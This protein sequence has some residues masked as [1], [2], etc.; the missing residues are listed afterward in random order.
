[1]R[2]FIGEIIDGVTILSKLPGTRWAIECPVCGSITSRGNKE[3]RKRRAS[4]GGKWQCTCSGVKARHGMT[5]TPTM[6]SWQG[7]IQRCYN[8]NANKYDDYGGRGISVCDR[9]RVFRNFL[10]DMGPRPEGT[11]LD[12]IDPNG[13]YEKS[14]CRWASQATQNDNTR[15]IIH[16]RF[17]GEVCNLKSACKAAGVNYDTVR[18]KWKK[19]GEMFHRFEIV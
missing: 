7:M 8:E 1:M 17:N 5:G 18:K 13:N 15:R 14:N 12:R 6:I 9:W 19:S 2:I 3:M 4:P 10:E 16:V 11:T